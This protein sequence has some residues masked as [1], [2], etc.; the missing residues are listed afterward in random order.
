MNPAA[1]PSVNPFLSRGFRPFFLGAALFAIVTMAAWL[2]VYR[3]G[4]PLR[5]TGISLFQWH[6]HE[7][8]YG[9]AMAVIAGFLLTAAWN[10]TE[11]ETASGVFLALIFA[12]WAAARALMLFGTDLLWFAAAADLAFM[13][14]LAFAVARPILQVRQRR[15]A[16][17]LL[18][19]ALLVAGNVAFYL[20]AAG[21]L[22][23]GVRIGVHGGL[24][25]VL[26][27]VLFM[28]SRV[29]PF[30]TERGVGY[31]VEL[32]KPRW[33]DVATAALYPLFLL[34]EV[35]L[36]QHVVGAVL[37]G[38][39]LVLNSLRVSGW[40]TLGIWRKPL[41]WGLFAAFIMINLGFLLRALMPVTAIPDFLPIHAYAVGGIGVVT[42]AMMARVSLGHTGRS[43]HQ[44]PLLVTPLLLAMVL[45]AV[46]R[47]FTPLADPAHYPL[48]I[49]LAGLA[50][51]VSFA[52][53][54]LVFVPML[55]RP[56]AD[57]RT[58][59]T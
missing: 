59:S 50:W 52:L 5:V 33:N 57:S 44:P 16:P 28:G 47:V 11:R 49:V 3:Y 31:E 19:L 39:L 22:P 36:P 1:P 40:H 23:N 8:V 37:A 34:T 4:L 6:A 46:I 58:D 26:G 10:W 29:I 18:L 24:Y 7:M 14:A 13:L 30:F 51:I 27:M 21:W 2:A 45:A 55:V 20:G 12:A 54:A 15:Q 25:L 17:V 43:I 41:L 56:R 48:W 35:F 53:F 42:V 32:K 38:G 9:Y